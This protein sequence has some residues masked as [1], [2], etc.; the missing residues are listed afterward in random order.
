MAL[1]CTLLV[2]GCSDDVLE[3][4]P[5]DEKVC[6]CA[7]GRLGQQ[8]C[9]SGGDWSES[10][11]CGD[12]AP[13][14]VQR[15]YVVIPSGTF[16]MGSPEDEPCRFDDETQHEVTL[17]HSFEL[18]PTE[19]TLGEWEALMGTNPSQKNPDCAR[20]PAEYLNWYEALAY[21]NARSEIL[22]LEACYALKGCN[23]KSPG[24]GMECSTVTVTA[25]DGDVYACEGYRLPTEAEWEYAARAGT[26]EGTYNRDID[27]E[28]CFGASSAL[29]PIAWY[30]EN[31]DGKSHPVAEKA[32][33]PWGL[34]DMLGNVWEWTWDWRGMYASD[35]M[36]D[37]TGPSDGTIRLY[38]GAS[39]YFS[40]RYCRAAVRGGDT[41]DHRNDVV[42]FR[43]ARTLFE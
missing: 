18:K 42:G 23:D 20:C 9:N 43:P 38:R 25:P 13:L 15:E 35:P 30:Q 21:C 14:L 28:D 8:S 4:L 5:G 41:P 27:G 22:G 36:V 7:N 11:V 10:C 3:C 17:T 26:T 16:M 24:H 29:E 32:P 12:D 1:I 19:V 31:S 40:A 39:W 6:L 2:T 33:N 34:Y 37:P